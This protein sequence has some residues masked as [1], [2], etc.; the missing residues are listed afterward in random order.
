MGRLLLYGVKSKGV[1]EEYILQDLSKYFWRILYFKGVFMKTARVLT[2]LAALLFVAV[3]MG[4]NWM[5]CKGGGPATTEVTPERGA[6]E[7]GTVEPGPGEP[8]EVVV[9]RDADGVP[10]S[11]DNCPTVANPD[12]VLPV[13]TNGDGIGDACEEVAEG[14]A[15]RGETPSRETRIITAWPTSLFVRMPFPSPWHGTAIYGDSSLEEHANG[16]AVSRSGDVHI[17]GKRYNEDRRKFDG[18]WAVYTPN[19]EIKNN[20]IISETDIESGIGSSIEITGVSTDNENGTYLVGNAFETAQTNLFIIKYNYFSKQWAEILYDHLA[21]GI[22][23]DT[24]P[25]RNFIYV[26]GK[27]ENQA[28]VAKYS[29]SGELLKEKK[30][31]T[32]YNDWARAVAVDA[33]GNVYVI[34][35]TEKYGSSGSDA[36]LAKFLYGDLDMEPVVVPF[37]DTL[38]DYATSL[39]ID[40]LNNIYVAGTVKDAFLYVDKDVFIKK[41]DP[42]LGSYWEKRHSTG[43]IDYY[44]NGIGI[45]GNGLYVAGC[46]SGMGV[47]YSLLK[48]DPASGNFLKSLNERGDDIECAKGLAMDRLGYIHLLIDHGVRGTDGSIQ[49][50]DIYLNVYNSNLELQ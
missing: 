43:E 25:R 21:Y 30:F 1:Q 4:P 22:A 50:Q 14:E 11:S 48:F 27:S 33:Y 38:L 49:Q 45:Y 26:V 36:F 28:F 24:G 34:G 6:P 42:G 10:D 8:G 18:F 31:G 40:S 13:D 46:F 12:Q 20:A 15:G 9:D 5:G 2:A 7:P 19:K 3:A 44:V 32:S 41:F 29:T 16:I 47:D 17:V 35:S 23:F 37:G 39:V